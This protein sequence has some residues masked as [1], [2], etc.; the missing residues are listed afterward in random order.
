M[1]LE[2]FI[3]KLGGILLLPPGINFLLLVVAVV[4]LKLSKV[5][6]AKTTAII[7]ITSLLVLSL[8][9]V[10][11]ALHQ[12]LQTIPSLSQEKVKQIARTE[13]S[14]IAIV[15]LSGGRINLAE[16]FGSIDTVSALTLQRIHY[17]TWLQRKTDLP[18]LVSGGSVFG[19]A[20][21]EAVLMNQVMVS[22][23]N[24][25]PRW[26]ET[27]SKNTAENAQYSSEILLNSGIKEILL[28]THASH[29]QRAI[30]AF[31]NYSLKVT[32]A[33]TVFQSPTSK[34]TDYL[35][36]AKA[37]FESQQALHEKLGQIWY[38]L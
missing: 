8:P 28:V 2:L 7:S 5:K 11:K 10:S 9:I 13:R 6:L 24:I 1:N 26:I 14:D 15:I 17:A 38:S 16:E 4:L 34:W 25:A 32:P 33:P 22:A 20:T 30:K 19:E 37:L 27:K 29:M 31:S 23:F 36:T 18:I 35:P 3:S 12:S 21:A